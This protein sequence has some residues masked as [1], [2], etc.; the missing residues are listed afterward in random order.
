MPSIWSKL[1]TKQWTNPDKSSIPTLWRFWKNF[2][3]RLLITTTS[4][5]RRKA[6]LWEQLL[7]WDRAALFLSQNIFSVRLWDYSVFLIEIVVSPRS[8]MSKEKNTKKYWPYEFANQLK[9]SPFLVNKIL[10]IMLKMVYFQQFATRFCQY[11]IVFF[12]LLKPFLG[13]CMISKILLRAL[14]VKL[15]WQFYIQ[16]QTQCHKRLNSSPYLRDVIHECSP[17]I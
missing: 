5:W 7:R 4:T 8:G 16:L 9:N 6:Q 12:S 3:G 1:Q 15:K 10:I 11:F 2:R 17:V 14:N 13:A